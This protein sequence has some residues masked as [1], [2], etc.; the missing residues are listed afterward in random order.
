VV[1]RGPETRISPEE[2]E[3]EKIKEVSDQTYGKMFMII[4]SKKRQLD[5]PSW[6]DTLTEESMNETSRCQS[7]VQSVTKKRD[8]Q[9]AKRGCSW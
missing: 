6:I 9:R 2:K 8:T 5:S 1:I 7:T 3:K 4:I